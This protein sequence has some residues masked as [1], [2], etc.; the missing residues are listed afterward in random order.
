MVDQPP[1]EKTS[2]LMAV[3]SYALAARPIPPR[4][5]RRPDGRRSGCHDEARPP[6]PDGNRL[7]GGVP[8]LVRPLQNSAGVSEVTGISTI[9]GGLDASLR[10]ASADAPY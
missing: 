6:G 9:T 5:H 8:G 10:A 3:E 4:A 1:R 2:D 7:Y